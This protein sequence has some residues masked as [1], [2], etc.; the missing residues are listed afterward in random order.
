[1]ADGLHY[2]D[3]YRTRV[4]RHG[5]DTRAACPCVNCGKGLHR[6]YCSEFIGLEEVMDC[7]FRTVFVCS[8]LP[9][10]TWHQRLLVAHG[11][12][13]RAGMWDCL[14]GQCYDVMVCFLRRDY[15]PASCR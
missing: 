11:T 12:H 9:D 1:M 4:A 13:T 15:P 2:H 8:R 5:F 14:E 10:G 3:G 7:G 6:G